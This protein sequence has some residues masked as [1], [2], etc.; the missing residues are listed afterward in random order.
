M[1]QRVRFG[2]VLLAQPEVGIILLH[3]YL[4]YRGYTC[5]WYLDGVVKVEV[6]R[7]NLEES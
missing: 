1:L 3:F 7:V 2:E 4:L 6:S 5:P